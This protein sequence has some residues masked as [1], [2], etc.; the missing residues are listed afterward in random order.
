MNI[1]RCLVLSKVTWLS[2][3]VP[4]NNPQSFHLAHHPRLPFALIVNHSFTVAMFM[5][6]VG[7]FRRSPAH[8]RRGP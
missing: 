8:N 7:A 3:V 1:A 2:G 5:P 4:T 6:P